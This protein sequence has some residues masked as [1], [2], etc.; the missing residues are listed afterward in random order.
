MGDKLSTTLNT[1]FAKNIYC[2]PRPTRSFPIFTSSH[3]GLDVPG[4]CPLQLP[5]PALRNVEADKPCQAHIFL[6]V[7]VFTESYFDHLFASYLLTHANTDLLK[8][9]NAVAACIQRK[10]KERKKEICTD[11]GSFFVFWINQT[12]RGSL[13]FSSSFSSNAYCS[14][15]KRPG[16]VTSQE[17]VTARNSPHISSLCRRKRCD[18][19]SRSSGRQRADQSGD[20]AVMQLELSLAPS[21]VLTSAERRGNFL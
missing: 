10:N 3:R 4:R 11:S 5:V 20:G 12:W 1:F 8:T 13:T 18:L 2:W 17:N 7:F 9:L 15:V 6:F 21:C 16:P 19:M 14:T